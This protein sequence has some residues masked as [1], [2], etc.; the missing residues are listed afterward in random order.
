MNISPAQTEIVA[1]R[2]LAGDSDFLAVVSA[3]SPG[4]SWQPVF[5]EDSPSVWVTAEPD[6]IVRV[7]VGEESTRKSVL[8]SLRDAGIEK[9]NKVPIEDFVVVES[10]QQ[11]VF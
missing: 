10:V 11:N 4:P 3:A 9:H 6:D 8:K 2:L 7:A 1:L 5:V